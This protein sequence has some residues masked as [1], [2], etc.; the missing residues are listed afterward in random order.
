[1]GCL[2]M[3]FYSENRL[4]RLSTGLGSAI[5]HL[6][7]LP[8]GEE[9]IDQRLTSFNSRYT[10]SAKEKDIETGYSYFGARYYTS[11]LSIW[12]SVDPMSDKLPSLTPYNYCMNNPVKLIDPN[13]E[14][15]WPIAKNFNNAIRQ[16]ISGMYRNFDGQFH[17]ATDIVHNTNTGNI[18]GGTVVATHNG[19]V[20]QSGKSKTAG[21]WIQITNGDIRTTYM[22]ME[23]APTQQIGDVIN[24]GDQVGTV[25]NTG[26]SKGPHLHYQIEMY[27][28]ENK[29][30][31]KTNPVEGDPDKVD[32]NS[33]VILKDP[34]KYINYRDGK[35][36]GSNENQPI[37]L[38][39]IEVKSSENQ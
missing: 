21:N 25:G 39:E 19:V 20:T 8:F 32:L 23:N 11:D 4:P 35:S 5:Q 17:G 27:N 37:L 1:M 6:H 10:F 9:Q 30:W 12:L 16:I 3:N 15:P 29:A 26:R 14:I 13:G 2:K 38:K 34:Q 31:E 24:E 33:D 28:E 18:S 22:H 36:Q 7:Y